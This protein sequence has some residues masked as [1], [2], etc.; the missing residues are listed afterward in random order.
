MNR[1]WLKSRAL[2]PLALLA[3]LALL[4][5]STPAAAQYFGR[6]KVQYRTFDFKV[7]ETPH[8]DIYYYPEEAAASRDAAR[9]AERWYTR[10]SRIFDHQFERRQPVVLYGSA[11]AFQQTTTVQ[12]SLGEGTGGITEGLKQRVILP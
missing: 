3:L 8:F 11:P 9:M 2:L 4:S 5:P 7:L 10:L 6:N 12:G 1:T